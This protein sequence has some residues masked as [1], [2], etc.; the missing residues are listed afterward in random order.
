MSQAPPSSQDHRTSPTDGARVSEAAEAASTSR[1]AAE[2]PGL[3]VVIPTLDEARHLP[4][5]LADIEELAGRGQAPP[6]RGESRVSEGEE[7]D[8][9]HGELDVEIIVV[10]GGSGDGTADLARELGARVVTT[11]P[12]RGHQLR[13]G[14][15]A[16]RGA[17]LFFV[18]ADSRLDGP[19]RSALLDFLDSADTGD[20]AHFGFELDGERAFHRLIEL[21]QR[22]RE[23]TLGLVYGDQGLVVSRV[24][25]R[26]AGGHPTWPVMEDV[27]VVR[28][29]DARGRRV[30]LPAR[31]RTSPRRYDEEGGLGRWL[32]NV[33]LM[34]LFRIGIDPEVLQR[35]YRP[36]RA[37]RRAVGVFAKAPTPGRVKTRLAADV[38][39]TR[40]TDIYR[41]MGRTTVEGLRHGP[42]RLVVWVTP[43]DAEAFDAVGRWLGDDVELRPQSDG[44]LGRRMARALEE[45]LEEA[46]EAVLVGT[47]IPGIDGDLV[48]D[49]LSS[50]A[51]HDLVVGPATDGGYY[52]IGMS[53]ARPELFHDMAWSTDGVLSE[54][55]RRAD[56]QNLRVALLEPRTDVD[57]V[58]DLPPDIEERSAAGHDTCSS[59][60]SC[61]SP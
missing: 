39:D 3:S 51:D 42:W 46:D 20:F 49:A 35:W 41:R 37:R 44:D 43:P 12:G 55:L 25:Y 47:D 4:S 56:A 24:L 36:R 1:P 59:T 58:E 15:E 53:Q 61:S 50:L 13:A 11:S 10:D 31:L 57:T 38:G 60:S 45:L 18:H 34:I 2:A 32:R 19:A 29:L 5:L 14:A 48:D 40:A 7:L 54:T 22:V 16:A 21:G 33:T 28:R 9:G 30:S 52:L 6:R 17:W 23:R 8:V 27:E 26:R